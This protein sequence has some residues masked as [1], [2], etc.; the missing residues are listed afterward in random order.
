M[1]EPI[2]TIGSY[3][4]RLCAI[5]TFCEEARQSIRKYNPKR[6]VLVISHTDGKGDGVIPPIDSSQ[7]N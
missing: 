6:D 2:V 1:P 3:P 4:P 5:A 7:R